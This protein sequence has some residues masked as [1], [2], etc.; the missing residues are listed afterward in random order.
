MSVSEQ[1]TRRRA[2]VLDW[3]LGRYEHTA[4]QLRPAARV[5]VDHAGVTADQRVVDVGCG[6]GNAALLAAARGAR[7]KGVD[8]A[9]RL[10]K[11]A[12][13]RA[14]ARGLDVTFVHG[15]AASLPL[16]DESADIVLSNF[17]VIF[18]ADAPAAADELAR[19]TAPGGRVVLTA[20]IPEGA[21]HE[22]GQAARAAITEVVG[23]PTGPPPFAWHD[24]DSLNGL[25]APAGLEATVREA[26][27]AITGPSPL[28]YLVREYASHPYAVVTRAILEPRGKLEAL[29]A[30]TL[31]ILE[32]ANED[33]AG[34]RVTSRY[35]V[36]T[37]SR[38]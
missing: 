6:T 35:V 38:R 34:F 17:G 4:Q 28:E 12:R 23:K 33:P 11:V 19:V 18:A 3:G 9:M 36:A 5:L 22:I 7:V 24:E 1:R 21:I 2:P 14:A 16:A 30:R 13:G 26:E 8:P 25:F 20:W 32:E 31:D 10:L 29:Q 27:I 15:E 37:A